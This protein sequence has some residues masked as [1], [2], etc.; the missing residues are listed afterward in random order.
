MIK[1]MIFHFLQISL[2][3]NETLV[4]DQTFKGTKKKWRLRSRMKP[5]VWIDGGAHAREWIAPA[6]AT[7]IIHA[8]VEGEK[9][10]GEV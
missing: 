8:L 6:V 7:W 4:K 10:L 9:G 1:I 3:S 2:P 5:A